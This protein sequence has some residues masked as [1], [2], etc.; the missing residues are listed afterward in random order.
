MTDTNPKDEERARPSGTHSSKVP[1]RTYLGHAPKDAPRMD[2]SFAC[3]SPRKTISGVLEELQQR[4]NAK[5]DAVEGGEDGERPPSSQPIAPATGLSPPQPAEKSIAYSAAIWCR[6]INVR[7][8]ECSDCPIR[9]SG[10]EEVVEGHFGLDDA[11]V[12]VAQEPCGRHKRQI[13]RLTVRN[14]ITKDA[15]LS[16]QF[17]P[18]IIA[19]GIISFL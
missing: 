12:G 14:K 15:D 18:R 3:I 6:G 2:T 10:A 17:P 4:I 11:G 9:A 13:D 7:L 1:L 16:F 19:S 8:F 5:D